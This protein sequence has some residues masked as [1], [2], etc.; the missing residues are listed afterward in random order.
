MA[1]IHSDT[2]GVENVVIWVGSA[3]NL[4][5]G[6]RIKV[7]NVPDRFDAADNF[8]IQIPNLDYDPTK[9]SKWIDNEKINQILTWIRVNQDTLYD[10]ETGAMDNTKLFLQKLEP[11]NVPIKKS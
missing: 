8:V 10:Y 11:W 4:Q 2:H 1:N 3:A 9:V 6:L 5:H 7:S